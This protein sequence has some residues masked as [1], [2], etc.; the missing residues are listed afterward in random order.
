MFIIVSSM[1]KKEMNNSEEIIK[2][3]LQTLCLRNQNT[4][5]DQRSRETMPL[6]QKYSSFE[7]LY[8][9]DEVNRVGIQYTLSKRKLAF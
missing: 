6:R 1:S 3:H 9:P 7:N 2:L 8:I 5:M 4:T